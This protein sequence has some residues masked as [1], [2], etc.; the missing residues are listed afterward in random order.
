MIYTLESAIPI[1]KN[2]Y[3]NKK[4]KINIFC[5]FFIHPNKERYNEILFC[6]HKNV[7]N[8]HID[9]IYL[10][11][12]R[13]YTSEELGVI[14]SNKIIQVDINKRLSYKDVFN[15]V[16]NNNVNGFFCIINS[17]IFFDETLQQLHLTN[18]AEEKYMF[19]QLRFEYDNI[20]KQSV[21]FGSTSAS[22]DTWIFHSNF[23][24]NITKY[25]KMFGFNL[26]MLGCDNKI[27]YLLNIIGF[28]IINDPNFIKTYHYHTTQI[29]NYSNTNLVPK[30]YCLINPRFYKIINIAVSPSFRHLD[31]LSFYDNDTIHNYISNKIT[32]NQAFIIPRIAGIENNVAVFARNLLL[33]ND[34][35]QIQQ[36]YQNL[37]NLKN[38][39]KN[40]AGIH[41]TDTNSYFQYSK[42]YLKAFENCEMYT[43]WEKN[44]EVYKYIKYS[45]DY[46]ENN[47]P[48]SKKMLWA[49][50]LDIFHYIHDIP[51]TLSLKGKKILLI[52]AFEESLKK[53]IPIRDKIYGIDL[54]PDCEFILLKP[55]QT[56]GT[57]ISLNFS[58][59]LNN[60]CTKL[61]TIKDDYDVAL[62]SCGGYGNLVCNYIFEKH[63]KSAIYV[64]GVLQ[65]YFGILGNRWLEERKD[66][67]N[68][69]LNQYWV[70][71][72]NSEKPANH[73]SVERGCY[74]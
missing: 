11:N 19:A 8:P 73:K 38:P 23:I 68:M 39:M 45:H 69:Y 28:K 49:F 62:V 21:I 18:L 2:E 53:Q 63:N 61:D 43:G 34:N 58:I 55:P 72:M 71:P 32:S 1:L 67:V 48:T 6:L 13:I 33:S 41:F 15:Y 56:Q 37:C 35:N 42:M 10:L 46:I 51:W 20:R 64:G 50:S 5:Q 31:N 17:D 16:D 40:N 9:K 57:E 59:E 36:F 24:K 25:N 47:L 4:D 12:E 52:S 70:R 7:Q 26:G 74:W 14:V 65:M 44:G 66:I 29:R 54:F 22:Q 27:L 60:F 30:P 3:G